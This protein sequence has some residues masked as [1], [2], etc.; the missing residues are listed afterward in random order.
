[1][2]C[3]LGCAGNRPIYEHF[4]TTS[5]GQTGLRFNGNVAAF[6]AVKEDNGKVFYRGGAIAL[7]MKTIKFVWTCH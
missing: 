3:I 2:K 1:M 6:D 7:Q 4:Y 5:E